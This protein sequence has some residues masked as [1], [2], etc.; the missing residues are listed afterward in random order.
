MDF[1]IE[2]SDSGRWYICFTD[3]EGAR[4]YLPT[5]RRMPFGEWNWGSCPTDPHEREVLFINSPEEDELGC[6]SD[7]VL[8]HF[9]AEYP[10]VQDYLDEINQGHA[11][12]LGL[13]DGTVVFELKGISY[14]HACEWT[15][16]VAQFC[17]QPMTC[18]LSH[19]T[20]KVIAAGN[21]LKAQ[22]ACAHLESKL[23]R[24]Y[25]SDR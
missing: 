11:V 25:T 13:L 4:R 19:G 16:E 18:R 23:N 8:A 17:G 3:P 14:A 1:C 22:A 24:F 5:Q 10:Y 12:H 7:D 21:T 20:L 9:V 15:R 2:I 6:T